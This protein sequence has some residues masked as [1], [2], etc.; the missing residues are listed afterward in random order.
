M[1]IQGVFD[2]LMQLFRSGAELEWIKLA[3]KL[4]Y[5]SLST[6]PPRGGAAKPPPSHS[7]G[8]LAG[9][10]LQA[11]S[12]P[13]AAAT[14]QAWRIM[15]SLNLGPQAK[16]GA[17]SG[18]PAPAAP[19]TPSQDFSTVNPADLEEFFPN[20]SQEPPPSSSQGGVGSFGLAPPHFRLDPAL[21]EDN[22]VDFPSFPEALGQSAMASLTM[23]DFED[24]LS[25]AL[26][27]EAGPPPAPSG[28]SSVGSTWMNYPHP[29]AHLLQSEAMAEAPPAVLDEHDVLTSA[30]ED[31]LISILNSG[32]PPRFASGHPA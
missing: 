2:Q 10:P 16:P 12:S 9:V 28:P 5:T 23:E 8:Q 14:Q 26:M 4:N 1:A 13:S 32:G 15:E 7:F 31:R 3:D 6:A 29:I 20:V 21:M 11:D 25:P 17:V 22:I 30:D 27:P 18:F 19:P 24:L